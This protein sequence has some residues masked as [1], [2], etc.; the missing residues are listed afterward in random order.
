MYFGN[1]DF[2][3]HVE[4]LPRL[5][6]RAVMLS[7]AGT[8]QEGYWRD[9]SARWFATAVAGSPR[10]AVALTAAGEGSLEYGR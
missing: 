10:D 4:C 6:A 5:R 1:L 7:G 8:Q 2:L 3:E 9:E